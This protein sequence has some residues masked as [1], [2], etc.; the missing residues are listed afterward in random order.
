[1]RDDMTKFQQVRWHARKNKNKKTPP[2]KV[3]A[4][5]IAPTSESSPRFQL[6]SIRCPLLV[7][8]GQFT[9]IRILWSAGLTRT[10]PD[11]CPIL[12]QGGGKTSPISFMMMSRIPT[13]PQSTPSKAPAH[14][15]TL[16]GCYGNHPALTTISSN[17]E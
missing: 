16:H 15:D 8:H 14:S 2:Q 4:F 5:A 9:V 12:V 11:L 3:S 13:V 10:L 17:D 6:P 1:M 7:L